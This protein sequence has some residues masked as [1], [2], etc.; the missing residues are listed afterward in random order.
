[1][2][3][4]FHSEG[5]ADEMILVRPLADG[6]LLVHANLT[7]RAG[8]DWRQF[9]VFPRALAEMTLT[10]GAL[11]VAVSLR[12]GRWLARGVPTGLGSFGHSLADPL[13]S[14]SVCIRVCPL[15][16]CFSYMSPFL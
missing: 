13:S 2:A 1:M 3:A 15:L 8:T 10:T 7:L 12:S 4:E 9:G 11:E 6:G 5:R 14:L 16:A